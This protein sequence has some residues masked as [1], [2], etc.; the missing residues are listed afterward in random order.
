MPGFGLAKAAAQVFDADPSVEGLILVK[1]GIFSFGT[2]ARQS[3]ERMIAL[4]SLAE[5]RLAKNRKS[6]FVSA[7]LPARAAR[8]ADVGPIVRGACSMPDDK[9]EGAWKRFVLDFCGND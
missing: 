9:I 4:V 7:K 3:Y 2:D 6:A 8:L 1:H 5:Q